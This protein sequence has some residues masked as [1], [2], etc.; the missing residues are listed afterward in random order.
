MLAQAGPVQFRHG[1]FSDGREALIAYRQ[2]WIANVAEQRAASLIIFQT[3]AG[4]PQVTKFML[5]TALLLAAA[6]PAIAQSG[7]QPIPRTAFSQRLDQDFAGADVNKDGF[8]DR[9]E[10]ER[11][12]SNSLAARKAEVL[13]QREEA[14][15]EL[16]GNKDGSLTLQEFN[17]KAAAAP[18]PKA[19]ATPAITRFDTN[20]DGKVSKAE[21][22]ASAM[23][24]FDLADKNKDGILSVDEQRARASR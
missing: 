9:S 21:S 14:F 23:A 8:I 1:P 12:E 10:L 3:K 5:P 6:G 18:L 17:A 22:R 2:G 13:R 11:A 24:Q 20:K 4:E 15:R 16:D 7:P 19:D